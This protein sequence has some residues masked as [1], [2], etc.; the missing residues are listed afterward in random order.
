M[1]P[2]LAASP[3]L[4]SVLVL[5]LGVAALVAVASLASC[6]A[7]RVRTEGGGP[8]HHHG[9]MEGPVEGAA[10]SALP[11]GPVDVTTPALTRIREFHGH[12]GPYVVLG[13]RMGLAARRI[14]ESPGY[15]DLTVDVQT[16]LEPP[17]SCLV[18]G[19]QLGSGCTTG[20]G[21]LRVTEG[22]IARGTFATRAGRAVAI[23]LRPEVPNRIKASIA[24]SGVDAAGLWVLD[25]PEE[26]VFSVEALR[27][28]ALR[29]EERR[30]Q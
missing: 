27:V 20:K 16:P 29:L 19:L 24:R 22:P 13:Y 30:G 23:A 2:R 5:V 25:L 11:H 6:G 7:P 4:V 26:E 15:F 12:I 14:L 8:W 18:D 17:P 10:P 1:A 9:D 28:D 3:V 21:N